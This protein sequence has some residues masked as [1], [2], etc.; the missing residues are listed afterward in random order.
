MRTHPQK[1]ATEQRQIG[2]VRTS[3]IFGKGV[4]TVNVHD[5]CKLSAPERHHVAA[6]VAA[7]ATEALFFGCSRSGIFSVTSLYF[8][9]LQTCVSH[10]IDL[11]V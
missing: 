8:M 10:R 11:T 2:S 5:D 3:L 4:V 1:Q 6:A 9:H 7:N